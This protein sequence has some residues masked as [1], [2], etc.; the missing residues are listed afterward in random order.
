MDEPIHQILVS[1]TF[2]ASLLEEPLQFWHRELGLSYSI[3]FPGY[4]QVF[5]TVLD[6]AGVF[7]NNR[8]GANVALFRLEDLGPWDSPGDIEANTLGLSTALIGAAVRF[9]VPLLVCLCPD[10]TRFVEAEVRQSLASSLRKRVTEQLAGHANLYLIDANKLA[11]D[12][13]VAK[14]DD[15]RSDRTGHIPYQNEF[16]IA[17][18]TGIV[19]TMMAIER[20][21]VKVIAVDCDNTLWTGVCGEDGP[22]GV[23]IEEG[24]RAFHEFL[25]EQKRA[26]QLL[27]LISKNNESDVREVF[28][29][30]PDMLLKFS[31]VSA[32]RINWEPKSGNV[33]ELAEE[34]NLAAESFLVLDDDAR[35]CGELREDCPDAL[36]L[37]V[38][39]TEHEL[40]RFVKHLWPLDQVKGTTA[41]DANRSRLYVEQAARK[42]FEQANSLR[43]FLAGLRLEIVFAPVTRETAARVTQLTQRT[44][45]MHTALERYTETELDRSLAGG[46]L[47]F[48]VAVSDRF[49]SYGLVGA[50]FAEEKGDDLR[51]TDFMLSCRALGRGV[52]HKMLAH[53]AEMA[54]AR[55]KSQVG[56]AIRRGPRNQPA[57]DFLR[58]TL[59]SDLRV[60]EGLTW[61][62]A[63][64]DRVK[65][66]ELRVGEQVERSPAVMISPRPAR[67]TAESIN[68]QRIATE[69]HSAKK[70]EDEIDRLRRKDA[71]PGRNIGRPPETE[72]E[73]KLAKIWCDLLGIPAVGI[74]EDFFDVGGHSLL[75]VQ[76]LSR[77]HQE[78]AVDLPDSVIYG[79]KLRISNLAH[80]IEF[81]RM[82]IEDREGYQA[83]LA[84][85]DSLSDEEVEAL[86]AQ[87]ELDTR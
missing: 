80:T 48:A 84:E 12:Y 83:A 62:Y 32:F 39:Q 78:L 37:Q 22:S 14:V 33:F 76:L 8:R 75:A 68:Y 21:P 52:E 58:S 43:E 73:G 45:Q 36:T 16:F 9:H 69:L 20:K 70:I 86:L 57:I 50:V 59:D 23:G 42:R 19:R 38:P 47:A 24:R 26:G 31:D 40:V 46:M 71:E 51:V 18:A 44:N 5:Q 41:E 27:T 49:G 4:Q 85:I 56:I 81:L 17:L 79:E 67:V 6:A 3:A 61:I 64:I 11:S 25:L 1:A 82:G 87:E 13:E 29:L 30:H 28:A 7:A 77:I 54:E 2:T 35:E 60:S 10:S 55:G 53:A 15:P 65:Y 72:L 66:L 34:L 63:P 74:D